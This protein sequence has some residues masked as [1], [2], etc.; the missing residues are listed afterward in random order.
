M[1]SIIHH[2]DSV[3]NKNR[4]FG[5]DAFYYPAIV[6]FEFARH[7]ALFTE[8]QIQA[9]I[10]RAAENPEDWPPAEVKRPWWKFW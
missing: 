9:A 10:K 6:Q 7:R 3:D 8:E 4:R 5:A 2:A 1:K